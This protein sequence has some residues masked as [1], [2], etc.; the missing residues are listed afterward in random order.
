[1]TVETVLVLLVALVGLFLSP[2]GGERGEQSEEN[3]RRA[4]PKPKYPSS[5]PNERGFD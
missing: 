3:T 4:K 2:R 5:S 1:M